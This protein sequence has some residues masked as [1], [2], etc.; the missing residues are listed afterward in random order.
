MCTDPAAGAKSPLVVS[1]IRQLGLDRILYGSDGP[2]RAAWT[3]FT[4]LPLTPAEIAAIA[5]NVAP[6][7]R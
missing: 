2:P 1:R 5:S 7:M 3:A 6:Y 4:H